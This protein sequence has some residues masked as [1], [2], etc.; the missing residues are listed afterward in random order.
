M[1]FS[2]VELTAPPDVPWWRPFD[3]AGDFNP[4]WW[5]GQKYTSVGHRF[6]SVFV[7]SDEVARLDLDDTL[8]LD[9]LTHYA[10]VRVSDKI[11]LEIQFIEVAPQHR[12]SRI[13]TGVIRQL[14]SEYLGLTG[15]GS[16][17]G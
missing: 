9:A 2:V 14:A 5:C 7:D 8:R 11:A 1:D 16:V 10:D 17:P 6:F 3:S 12:R 15:L 13:G 4:I